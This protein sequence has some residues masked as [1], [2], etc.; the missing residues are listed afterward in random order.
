M[1]TFLKQPCDEAAVLGSPESICPDTGVKTWV[2]VA[3]IL[4]S[5]MAFIDGTAVNVALPVLQSQLN[6]TAAGAQWVIEAYSLFL[7]ALLLVGGA[8]G[9]R[10]GRRLIY[11]I[12]VSLFT[13]S[14]VA[15]G[16]APSLTILI[17]ARAVQGIGAALLV[18]GS[19]AIISAAFP[20]E[21]RGRA[22]GTW[23][24]FGAI[25]TGAGPVLGGW[26]VDNV[27]WRA[28]FFLNVPVAAAVLLLT[29]TR[30]PESRDENATGSL[31]WLGAILV[32]LG[33]GGIVYGLIEASESASAGLVW[34]GIVL[35]IAALAAFVVVEMRVESPMMPLQLFRSATFLGANLLTL[36]LYGAL[37]GVLFFVPFNLIRV[38]GYS[39]TE[40]G[41][42]F[43]PFIVL[44]FV[45]SR[46][47]GG[48][49]DR[50]GPKLP[51]I[52]GPLVAAAGMALL[53][54]PGVGGSYWTTFFPAIVVLSLGMSIAVAPLTTTV[55][56]A[57]EQ[58]HVGIASGIN[59]AAS[60]VAGLL[61]IAA[62]S[63]VA[64]QAFSRDF[65][66]RLAAIP[67]S[68]RA[69]QALRAQGD[70]LVAVR[71]PSGLK[72]EVQVS[73]HQAVGA[74]FVSSFRIVMVI[75]AILALLSALSAA[76]LIERRRPMLV[77]RRAESKEP[78]AV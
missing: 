50:Y 23:S 75:G 76:V 44:M 26:L 58:H 32:T 8:L 68:A 69:R 33:L 43:L 35:G 1:S 3:T 21:E 53:A 2:L 22:I 19:L 42:A 10:L 9:D 24:G 34:G 56:N 28:V 31:D 67:L 18:P 59:N 71:I 65:D 38:Q 37:S 54:V 40:S 12:G 14:S 6:A 15:C 39:A 25:T 51:L 13:L 61:T 60:R 52:V 5:S 57:V 77:V 73:L 66:N 27:S 20:R 36:F 78:A 11:A 17:L 47:S 46:W 70:R 74:S 72:N 41:A 64:V 63:I 30:I 29:L 7:G 16:L 4:G 48:L 62:F 49:V 45:L 55:M